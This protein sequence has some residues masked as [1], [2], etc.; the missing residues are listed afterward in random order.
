MQWQSSDKLYIHYQNTIAVWNNFQIVNEGINFE[1]QLC[2]NAQLK[3]NLRNL[4]L[5]IKHRWVCKPS[6]GPFRTQDGSISENQTVKTDYFL[7]KFSSVFSV[8]SSDCLEAHQWCQNT[9]ESLTLSSDLLLHVSKNLALNRTEMGGGQ[10]M[11]E[12]VFIYMQ[13]Y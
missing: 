5:C 8:S 13:V 10:G 1:Y 2:V 3:N 4:H 7:Q 9:I 11:R 6:V 12:G